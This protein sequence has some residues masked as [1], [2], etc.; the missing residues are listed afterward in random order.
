MPKKKKKGGKKERREEEEEERQESPKVDVA[1]FDSTLYI[2][3]NTGKLPLPPRCCSWNSHSFS[4]ITGPCLQ[5][6]STGPTSY[7]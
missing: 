6:G 3:L 7:V 5:K 2:D 4:H 1:E